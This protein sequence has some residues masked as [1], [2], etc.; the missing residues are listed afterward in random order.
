MLEAP[1]RTS[2]AL[3]LKG[4]G[5]AANLWQ[6]GCL[7]SRDPLALRPVVADGL[8]LNRVILPLCTARMVPLD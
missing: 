4:R 8:P 3:L 7:A 5:A 1:Q 2:P 6:L